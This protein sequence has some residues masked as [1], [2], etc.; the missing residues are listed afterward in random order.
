MQEN[1]RLGMPTGIERIAVQR[2]AV[3]QQQV[4][5]SLLAV[6]DEHLQKPTHSQQTRQRA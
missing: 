2:E 4:P 3:Q 1:I 5:V 6:A